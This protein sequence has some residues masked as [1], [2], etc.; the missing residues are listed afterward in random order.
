MAL[1]LALIDVLVVNGIGDVEG[2]ETQDGSS[3]T[4]SELGIPLNDS[5]FMRM[6]ICMALWA[7]AAQ[8]SLPFLGVYQLSR[9]KVSYLY[10]TLLT[11]LQNI[12][13]FVCIQQWGKLANKKSWMW[14]YN[15][16]ILLFVV[17]MVTWLFVTDRHSYILPVVYLQAGIFGPAY[18]MATFNL[19]YSYLKKES[20]TAY[21]S[22][23]TIVISAANFLGVIMGRWLLDR[24][25][26][27][28]WRFTDHYLS[29]NI[30]ITIILGIVAVVFGGFFVSFHER[31]E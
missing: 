4:L 16:S 18:T 6:L 21:I 3:N 2:V 26:L 25:P 31:N 27:D 12:I 10:I 8:I 11:S 5:Y 23:T 9:L 24:S 17:Q 15:L 22:I 20:E 29:N 13:S 19:P 14:I 30:A 7:F 28:G 1:V